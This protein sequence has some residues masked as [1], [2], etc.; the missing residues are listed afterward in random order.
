V[1]KILIVVIIILSL[2]GSACNNSKKNVKKLYYPDWFQNQGNAEYVHS[3]GMAT[4]VSKQSSFDTAYK[5]AVS[6]IDQ[7]IYM[8][9]KGRLKVSFIEDDDSIS[10]YDSVYIAVSKK[11]YCMTVTKQETVISDNDHF[12]SFIQVSIPMEEVNKNIMKYLEANETL[13]NEFKKFKGSD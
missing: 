11:K 9:L 8:Y 4:R 1:K 6:Q 12:Q 3:Y 10:L 13:F 7:Y 5:N 2:I